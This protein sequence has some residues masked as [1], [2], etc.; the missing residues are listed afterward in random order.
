MVSLVQRMLDLHKRL[1]TVK[2]NHERKVL[3]RQ[4][5][6]TDAEIDALVYELYGLTQ[7]EI[8]LVEAT[9]HHRKPS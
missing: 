3:E 5:A 9:D 1:Q 2:T 7:E 6:A 4:I 8:A